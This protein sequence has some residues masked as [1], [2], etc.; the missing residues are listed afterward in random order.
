MT[1][2]EAHIRFD[3][4]IQHM[5]SNRKGS[6][7][8]EYVDL[9]LDSATIALIY[10][11]INP[12][13]SSRREGFEESL[14]RYTDLQ[15]LKRTVKLEVVDG[16]NDEYIAVL[17]PSNML[18]VPSV[19]ADLDVNYKR[20]VAPTSEDSSYKFYLLEFPDSGKTDRTTQFTAFSIIVND[21]TLTM[22]TNYPAFTR[23]DAKFMIHNYIVNELR[24]RGIEVG[25]ETYGDVFK[26]NHFVFYS[27]TP[28]IA[29]L[30]FD[31]ITRTVVA[32]DK[33]PMK[34]V[35][36]VN[37]TKIPVSV[38]SDKSESKASLNKYYKTYCAR[39]PIATISNNI[40][41]FDKRLEYI[42][43]YVYVT[44]LKRPRLYNFRTGAVAELELSDEILALAVT[45][46]LSITNDSTYNAQLNQAIKID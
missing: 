39:S 3:M 9:V 45:E 20:L 8:P 16:N 21:V 37:K 13:V 36:A 30:S 25:W 15:V 24:D 34:P 28:I 23:N 12:Y 26:R 31:A 5:A 44:Y 46:S 14:K 40:L 27:N 41:C 2:K 33:F 18:L 38:F 19:E 22:P 17:P 1:N 32:L 6:L 7:E 35:C 4:A 43:K 29:S 11:K 10:K 42:P